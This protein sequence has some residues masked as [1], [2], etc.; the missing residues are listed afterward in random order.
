MN[1]APVVP[2]PVNLI[3]LGTATM[4]TAF[5]PN[6]YPFLQMRSVAPLLVQ[7]PGTV[8]AALHYA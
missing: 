8:F 4:P 7:V 1:I 2:G 6:P 3:G 5:D